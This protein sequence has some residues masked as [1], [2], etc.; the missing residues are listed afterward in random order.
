MTEAEIDALAQQLLTESVTEIN[1]WDPSFFFEVYSMEEEGLV[2]VYG[3]QSEEGH[4][5]LVC[6]FMALAT[7]KTLI[8]KCGQLYDGFQAGLVDQVSNAEDKEALDKLLTKGRERAI[9]LIAR[10]AALELIGT[11]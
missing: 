4:G 5:A 10:T 6:E 2:P 8:V 11:F 7:I 1:S 3:G 9:P